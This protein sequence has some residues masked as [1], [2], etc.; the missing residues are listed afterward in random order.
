MRYFSNMTCYVTAITLLDAEIG[1]VNDMEAVE[2]VA[3]PCVTTEAFS[4]T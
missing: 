2:P 4:R 3:S 1:K